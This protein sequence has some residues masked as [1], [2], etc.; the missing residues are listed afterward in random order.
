MFGKNFRIEKE[1]LKKAKK[2]S[3]KAGY[4]SVEE[5]I[6]HLI[7]RELSKADQGDT[8]ENIKNRLQGLGYL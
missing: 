8:K 5:F 4:S 7:E 1:L 6:Q 2:Y 3:D